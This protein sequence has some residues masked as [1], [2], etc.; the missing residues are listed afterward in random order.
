[1]LILIGGGWLA[2][3]AVQIGPSGKP[4]EG[5][6]LLCQ[7]DFGQPNADLMLS[8]NAPAAVQE[9]IQ[10]FAAGV[11][12]CA[13]RVPAVDA[14]I[15]NVICHSAHCGCLVLLT[16]PKGLVWLGFNVDERSAL[17]VFFDF[18]LTIEKLNN[19]ACCN[20]VDAVKGQRK[21]PITTNGQ[22]NFAAC[23]FLNA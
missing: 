6:R 3:L 16:A 2:L 18:A 13:V 11:L 1:L 5:R 14:A 22:F 21:R 17:V 19:F 7:I 23:D 4:P 10:H 12:D 20:L 8:L 15:K 9:V